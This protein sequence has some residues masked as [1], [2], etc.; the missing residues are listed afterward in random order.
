M[1]GSRVMVLGSLHSVPAAY[2]CRATIA[3]RGEFCLKSARPLPVPKR[4]QR[5]GFHGLSEWP[6]R[7]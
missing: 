1:V 5:K 3:A 6:L 7:R 2:N 4:A